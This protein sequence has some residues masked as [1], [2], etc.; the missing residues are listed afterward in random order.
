[1]KHTILYIDDETDN[2]EVFKACFRHDFTVL[3]AASP[4]AGLHLLRQVP[5]QLIISDYKMP[6]Q[7]GVDFFK[8][9]ITE[10]PDV[11]RILLTAYN[12]SDIV[13][14]SINEGMVYKFVTKPWS[15]EE[16]KVII[17]G[18]LENYDLKSKNK[19]L[20]DE[21]KEANDQLQ[22]INKEI[23]KL[24]SQVDAENVYLR[25]EIDS[26]HNTEYIVGQSPALR[27]VMTKVDQVARMNTTVLLL[28]ETGTGKE[29]VARAIHKSSLR[30][31]QPF[32]KLNCAALPATLVESELFGYEKGAFTGALQNKVGMFEIANGGTI[33]L[34]EIGEMPIE[35][36][37]KLLRVLQD[38]EFYRIGASKPIT[39]DVRVIAATNRVLEREIEKGNF[40][41]DLYYRLNI[42]P[43]RIPA[44]RDRPEDIPLLVDHFVSIFQRKLG[45]AIKTVPDKI[46]K[47]LINHAWPGN[48]RELE[49]VIER[50]MIQSTG[51]V[52]DLSDWSSN[53]IA[54]TVPQ[55]NSALSL[56][57]LEKQHIL[58][59]L[60]KVNWKISG[61]DGAAEILKLNHNTLRSKMIKFGIKFR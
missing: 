51:E 23:R 54:T 61:K 46:F 7:N 57:D 6:E 25:H 49:G 37:A 38:G 26:D 28:G 60:T 12:E 42:F 8:Q 4:K 35:M 56:H 21:L 10:F 36:Q 2:L 52:L 3:T 44:L 41:S 32:V 24:K 34:D 59:V 33:F 15:K 20:I 55:E 22:K 17:L 48:I 43:I 50:S 9:I 13:I 39:V 47:T 53:S 31:D 18:A 30:R 29:L 40:R 27:L 58:N 5:V 45:I 1:M 11:I 14:R 16:L 19:Q